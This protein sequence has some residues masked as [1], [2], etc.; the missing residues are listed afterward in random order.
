[1]ATCCWVSVKLSTAKVK[2]QIIK[3]AW[4]KWSEQGVQ[5]IWILYEALIY[6]FTLVYP[7]LHRAPPPSLR[8]LRGSHN[9]LLYSLFL[10]TFTSPPS[11][12]IGKLL[13]KEINKNQNI[14]SP[15]MSSS[16][17]FLPALRTNRRAG[18]NYHIKCQCSYL[19]FHVYHFPWHLLS[20]TGKTTKYKKKY[21]GSMKY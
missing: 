14:L 1:M 17:S 10:M 4:M 3:L 16:P 21:I 18:F 12:Q 5:N 6:D 9:R 20:F 7:H 15:L 11:L 8:Y 13:D 2:Y 19:T